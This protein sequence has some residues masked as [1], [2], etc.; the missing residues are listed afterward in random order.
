MAGMTLKRLRKLTAGF[1]GRVAIETGT[2]EAA[3][4]RLL[5]QLFQVVHTI[6]LEPSRF[7]R[8]RELLRDTRAIC[9]QGDSALIL[10]EICGRYPD[11]PL[12][13]YLDAHHV[14]PR[15]RGPNAWPFPV[16]DS[17]PL[18]SELS[19]IAARTQPDRVVVDDV[20]AFGRQEKGWR[21][22]HPPRLR[23]ALRRVRYARTRADQWVAQLHPAD[24]S[25]TP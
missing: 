5:L 14:A 17:F 22:V 11:E 23:Q 2:F 6:E 21:Q 20:H 13:F 4:T 18:W 24:P 1:P 19:V 9:H 25:P 10:P 16:A 12:F 7:D 8:C 3:T 15:N